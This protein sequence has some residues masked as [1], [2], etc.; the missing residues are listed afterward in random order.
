MSRN[1]AYDDSGK[2]FKAWRVSV[3]GVDEIRNFINTVGH[4]VT[5]ESSELDEYLATTINSIW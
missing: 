1:K 2:T 4:I 5:K 3:T